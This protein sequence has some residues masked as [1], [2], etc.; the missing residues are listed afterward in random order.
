MSWRRALIT[1]ASAGIGAAFA[2]DLA[3]RGTNL[4]LVARR[5]RLLN[6]LAAELMERHHV[7]CD[8]MVADLT[9]QL[10]LA[11]VEARLEDDSGPIDL[12]VNNAGG[13]Y[14]G[15]GPFVDHDR[16]TLESQMVL[17]A[18]SVLRLTHAAL[19][20]MTVRRHGHVI[21]VSAGVAFYPAPW[22][23]T[24]AASK[25]FVNSLSQAVGFELSRTGVGITIVCP[26]FTRTEGPARNGFSEKNIPSWWWTDPEVVVRDALAGAA[27]GKRIVSPTLV[28]KFNARFGTHFPNVMVRF[29]GNFR[30]LRRA[31]LR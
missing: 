27:R 24:Y 7:A 14:P 12:L 29:S 2:R 17:N 5:E 25:A 16:D 1:G 20:S 3:A 9:D 15:P 31:A 10:Q 26:G 13:G 19:R 11:R 18:V 21:Q 28:N 4:V 8:V 22:G 6:D 30:P 23:A